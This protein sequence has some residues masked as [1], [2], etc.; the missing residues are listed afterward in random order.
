[1]VVDKEGVVLGISI[2]VFGSIV[3]SSVEGE[4]VVTGFGFIVGF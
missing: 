4:G 1:M 3:K 2:D